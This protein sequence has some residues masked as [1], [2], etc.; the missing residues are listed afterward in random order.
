MSQN[1]TIYSIFF[2][3]ATLISF[4]VAFLAWQRRSVK[5]AKE[6]ISLMITAGIWT[7]FIIFETT[8]NNQ[9]GK[10]LWAK[11]AYLGAVTTP[12][13]YF[14]LVL[15]FTGKKWFGS[16]KKKLLLF[17]VPFVVLVLAITNDLH[18]LIWSGYSAISPETNLMEYDHGVLFWIGY[19]GY[20]YLILIIATVL[21]FRFIIQN[22]SIFMS[23]GIV[24]FTAGLMPWAASF[25]YLTGINVAPGFDIVPG[26]MVLGGLLF[27]YSILYFR[28]INVVPV[29]REILIENLGEGILVLDE[30]NRIQDINATAHTLLKIKNKNVIGLTA[31]LA[32]VE[33][34]KLMEVVLNKNINEDL[35]CEFDGEIKFFSVEKQNIKNYKGSRIVII[36]DISERISFRNKLQNS[37]KRYRE[38]TEFLP[39]MI[40]EV[41]SKGKLK[42]ANQFAI[43]KLGFTNEEIWNPNFNIFNIF[44]LDLHGLIAKKFESIIKTGEQFTNEHIAL[45]KNGEEF[46][47]LIYTSPIY[48]SLKITGIRGVMVDITERKKYENEIANNLKQ[49]EIL[50]EIS[51]NYN[52]VKEFDNK[53]KDAL[54]IIGE[55][56]QV[57]RVYIFENSTDGEKTNNTYEW[58]NVNIEP[59]ID[60]LQEIPYEIIPSW[61]K[62]LLEKGII[63]SENI[64]ELPE[65]IRIFLEP[66]L[67]KAIIVLPLYIDNRFFG[68]IGFDECT[69]NRKWTKSEIELL[70]TISNIISNSYLRK[71]IDLELINNITE[72]KGIID[73]IPDQIM[74]LSDTGN[75]ISFE[76]SQENSLFVSVDF[77][78]TQNIVTLL[79]NELG[80]K[81]IHTINE[82]LDKETFKFDF[83]CIFQENPDF[84]EARLVKLRGNEV[85]AIIRNVTESK[86]REKELQI[87]KSKAEE[88]SMAKSEFLAN[89]S[90]E[91]RTP[92]NAILGFSE[93]LYD[94]TQNKL[95]RRYLHTIL[96]SGKNLLV[97]INDILDLSKIES[98]K[99]NIRMEP[100]QIQLVLNEIE[101]VLKQKIE[102]KNLA[103]SVV[104]DPNAPEYIYMDEIRF[105]QILFN[106]ISNAVKYTTKGFVRVLVKTVQAESD[107]SL[108]LEIRV[109]DTGIGIQE[110]Q[111]ELIF[112]AFTQQSGQSN[113]NY[114]GTGLGLTIVKG[115][116]NKLNADV[117]LNSEIGKGSVF[118]VTFYNIEIA[119]QTKEIDINHDYSSYQLT[120]PCKILIVDDVDFNINVLKRIIYSDKIV[121]LEAKSGRQ[122]L[123]IL[124]TEEPDLIFMDIWMPD[125][126]GYDTTKLIRNNKK[127]KKIPIVAFSASTMNNEIETL[128]NSFD[129][130]LHKPILKKDVM[131]IMLKLLP[132]KYVTVTAEITDK[133][134]E[135]EIGEKTEN[136]KAIISV[137]E[138]DF[139]PIWNNIKN[140]L[141]IFEIE[142]FEQKLSSFSKNYSCN[143]LNQF[144]LE[145]K[146][147]IQAF[148]I[149]LINN[150]INNFPNL[151]SRIK[152]LV[153]S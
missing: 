114:E 19:M 62:I 144:C 20:N 24:V 107:N 50:S 13:F 151:I 100:M 61:K 51:L 86:E 109:E 43:Q 48:E 54:R 4:F 146:H 36:R 12:I 129:A 126:N 39:E 56:T 2:I 123:E 102:S 125:L 26:S 32:I 124:Q 77:T 41:D 143:I 103:F 147:E 139:I 117:Q 1:L 80:N 148:D 111:Q 81:F 65:D 8:S 150:K 10:I 53:T 70:R 35:E 87:A 127:L 98:G 30:N 145:L 84:Y 93:W 22:T 112:S 69:V 133:K 7:F 67:V 142:E 131:E 11:I 90:H 85:M 59:Q 44:P 14:L 33:S 64:T 113:R 91:I 6:L 153:T 101:L 58:C 17:I 140:D 72:K 37:E 122:A 135:V 136:L 21:L 79:G 57:S 141:I 99:M 119:D 25:F 60:E 92:M 18:H 23:Q 15:S 49:Q 108:N 29:A 130:F 110:N 66:Q 42:Y 134:D 3:S 137:L 16:N 83:E 76:S 118:T 45:K 88:A 75:I 73:S 138:N 9:T 152:R 28:F 89:V 55:H 71:K 96:N 46:P 82:C 94:N 149:E 115:L 97:L 27:A 116:L 105:Y 47:V 121:F 74:L 34:S 78:K 104:I 40:C 95:H 120:E 38:L 68:F 52:S 31:T 106:L 132:H 63:Y 128:S 5:S